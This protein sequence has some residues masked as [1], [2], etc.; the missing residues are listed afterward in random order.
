MGWEYEGLFDVI[1]SDSD[2]L[3]KYWTIEATATRIGSMGYR[4]RTIKAR[5]RLEAE[6]YPIFGRSM[7]ETAKRVKLNLTRE[8]QQQ[9]NTKRSKRH[10][11]LLMENN[12][13]YEKDIHVTLTYAGREPTMDRCRKDVRNWLNRVKRQR[14]KR[15]LDKVKYIYAIGHDRDQRIHVHCVMNGGIGRDELERMWGKGY[16]NTIRL[17]AQGGGL[18]GMANYLYRQNEKA[19]DNGERA[20]CHMWCASRNLKKPKEH[21][22]DTKLSNRK[23]KR[24]ALNFGAAGK[25]IMEKTYP[26]YRIENWQVLFS[27]VVDGVYI[28]CV[29]RKEEQDGKAGSMQARPDICNGIGKADRHAFCGI[30]N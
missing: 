9:L 16:A 22:S 1:P 7:E 3:E 28:R 6:V 19:R 21:V 8:R 14:E 27:D 30:G 13:C 5:T 26:G 12:F 10:L 4:T 17:Q 18:Q 23:V 24:A 20:G 11:V 29:M 15:G 25:E 2:L